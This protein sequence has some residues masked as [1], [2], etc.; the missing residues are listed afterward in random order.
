MTKY[1]LLIL[2]LLLN[3]CASTDRAY[4]ADISDNKPHATLK[5]EQRDISSFNLFGV[6]V[7]AIHP[8]TIDG[9]P[10]DEK[11]ENWKLH[12]FGE[13]RIP[14]G[15]TMLTVSYQDRDN[16]AQ[17]FVRFMAQAGKTYQVTHRLDDVYI[18]FDVSDNES[19][20]ITT[21]TFQ[22]WQYTWQ[23]SPE[24]EAL[25]HAAQSGDLAQVK[26]SLKQ[27]ANLNWSRIYNKFK[28]ITV[29]AANGHS[30]IVKTLV[31]AGAD[32]NPINQITPLEA[33]CMRGH[34][35]VVK[36]LLGAGA[37]VDLGTPLIFAT[38]HGHTDIVR[39][40]LDKG[41][42]TLSR[43]DKEETAFDVAQRQGYADIVQ[44]LQAYPH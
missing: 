30:D 28:P 11:K 43:N 29:A 31:Q 3:A 1:I 12:A 4:F 13:F 2:S 44:L 9:I 21:Q 37:Y 42:Y 24:D 41:A 10:V 39:L 14:V 5:M 27:G 15:D 23:Q 35:R 32:I 7:A 36:L 8:L 19:Q 22:K 18:H 17:G 38:E 40:L 26:L 20:H 16:R 25:L 33:A 6:T 34:T